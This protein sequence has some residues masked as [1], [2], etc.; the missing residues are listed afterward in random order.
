MKK[1]GKHKSTTGIGA[2]LSPDYREKKES[3]KTYG[4]NALSVQYRISA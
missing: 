3:N 2:R 4:I 1:K